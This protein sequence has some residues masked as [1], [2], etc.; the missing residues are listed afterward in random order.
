MLRVLVVGPCGAGKSTLARDLA[1]KLDLPLIHMDQLN[2][3]PGWVESSKAEVRERLGKVVA[4]ERWVIDGT[5]GGTLDIRT[6]RA[7]TIVYLDYPITLCLL[8][9][10]KRIVTGWGETRFDMTDGCPERLDLSFLWY[11][12][13][14]NAGPRIRLHD[15]LEGHWDKVVQLRSP[16]EA[17]AW[18]D[19]IPAE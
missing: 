5:Y 11:V 2:W 17:T 1:E 4:K 15:R 10:L 14:W 16:S 12:A 7:D 8:R 9:V 6:P 19:S 3:K 13:R 18:L